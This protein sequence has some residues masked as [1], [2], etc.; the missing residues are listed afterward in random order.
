MPRVDPS[1]NK[2]TPSVICGSCVHYYVTWDQSF[3]YGCRAMG[4]KCRT[5][6]SLRVWEASGIEC[7]LYV[8]KEPKGA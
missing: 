5:S 1:Q 4:F 2:G 3:P 6:P 8:R 7:Q